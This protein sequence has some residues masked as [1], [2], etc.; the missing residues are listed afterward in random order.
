LRV[1]HS[2][3]SANTELRMSRLSAGQLNRTV[4]PERIPQL[5]CAGRQLVCERRGQS[6]A[7]SRDATPAITINGSVRGPHPLGT[8]G[9]RDDHEQGPS[10]PRATQGRLGA[11]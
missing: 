2:R 6:R 9:N 1:R 4:E 11:L 5:V 3:R 7:V 10:A 8:A